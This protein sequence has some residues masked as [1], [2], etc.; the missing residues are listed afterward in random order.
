MTWLTFRATAHCGPTGR[1]LPGR[2]GADLTQEAGYDAA[3][4]TGLAILATLQQT[5]VA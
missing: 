3:R 4:Q 1:R 2:V 5:W